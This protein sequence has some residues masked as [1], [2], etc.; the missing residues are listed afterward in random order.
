MKN[1]VSRFL[2]PLACV[3]ALAACQP[4]VD[5]AAEKAALDKA[6]EGWPTAYNN[7]DADAVAAVY[8]DDAQ[9]LPP[10]PPVAT[11]H[12]AIKAYWANDIA[13]QWARTNI[14][15]E[16]TDMSGDWAWRAGSW[17]TEGSP[18][19]TGKYVEIWHKTPAGWK[20]HRDIWNIDAVP[21]APAPEPAAEPAPAAAK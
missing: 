11:G 7:K 15:T 4:K 14:H 18:A 5:L 3:I 17:S 1:N 20:L 6:A 16:S 9:L 2:L 13:T 8:S 10:G 19:L 12:D 21:A